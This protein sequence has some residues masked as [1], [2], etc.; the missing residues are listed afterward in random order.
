MMPPC[1]T[2]RY[3]TVVPE[4][5]AQKGP[6]QMQS[7]ETFA[8]TGSH[9]HDNRLVGWN[10][11]VH[12]SDGGLTPNPGPTR[13]AVLRS[14]LQFVSTDKEYAG[15]SSVS[16]YLDRVLVDTLWPGD[17]FHMVRTECGGLAVSGLRQGNLIFAAGAISAVPLG[18]QIQARIPM[19][20]IQGAQE[21]FRQHDPKFSFHELPIEIR[22]GATCSILFRDSF[23]R[24]GY[25]VWVKHGFYWGGEPGTPECAAI[26]LEGKCDR[27]AA[28]ASAQLLEMQRD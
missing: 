7:S 6:W 8:P 23:I 2:F 15:K 20:L 27:T 13:P 3:F 5:G 17:A 1:G 19:D 24:N 14:G 12:I 21:L 26:S 9:L 11:I 25:S 10:P 28:C 16:Y 18:P 22:D 4:G